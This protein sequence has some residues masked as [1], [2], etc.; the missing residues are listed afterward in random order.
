MDNKNKC[1][2]EI[3]SHTLDTAGRWERKIWRLFQ[4]N[5]PP[6]NPFQAL[7]AREGEAHLALAS[8]LNPWGEHQEWG[9]LWSFWLPWVLVRF[10]LL[11][12]FQSQ[13]RGIGTICPSKISL[14]SM[15]PTWVHAL[16]LFLSSSWPEEELQRAFGDVKKVAMPCL[17]FL[18]CSVHNKLLPELVTQSGGTKAPR[19][20]WGEG[21]ASWFSLVLSLYG[22]WQVIPSP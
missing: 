17:R 11:P 19:M 16:V 3:N 15:Y 5:G 20:A 6:G 13:P 21:F 10:G 9:V 12:K 7:P 2:E 18:P 22:S 8:L 4:L 14:V 1:R